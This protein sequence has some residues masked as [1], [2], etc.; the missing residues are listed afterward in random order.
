[1]QCRRFKRLS[2]SVAPRI[3]GHRSERASSRRPARTSLGQGSLCP[4]MMSGAKRRWEMGPCRRVSLSAGSLV[5]LLSLS[6]SPTGFLTEILPGL[7][8]WGA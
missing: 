1:M 2:T 4:R 5:R 8:L 6:L 3:I 7:M